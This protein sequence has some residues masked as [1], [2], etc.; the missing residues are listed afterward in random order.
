MLLSRIF[1]LS[2]G[3][4]MKIINCE[5]CK[6]KVAEIQEGSLIKKGAVMLCPSCEKQRAALEYK[7]SIQERKG[8]LFDDIF[9]RR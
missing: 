8:G 4:N 1:A 5:K 7:N 3:V 9:G 2:A 6:T